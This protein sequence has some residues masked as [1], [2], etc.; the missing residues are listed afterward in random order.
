MLTVRVARVDEV[1]GLDDGETVPAWLGAE[2]RRRW[3]TLG[4]VR[5]R[6]FAAGRRLLRDTLARATGLPA[7]IWE[8]SAQAGAAPLVQ[9]PATVRA[10]LSHRL[11]WMAAA[12]SDGAVGIDVEPARP[13]RSDPAGRAALMLAPAELV[14]WYALAPGLR[15]AALRTA[16]TAKEAWFKASPPHTTAWDFRRVVA[17]A[18]APADANVRVW[19]ASPLHVAVCSVDARELARV[20]CA[21]LGSIAAASTFWHVS[22]G[23]APA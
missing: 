21:G 5:R 7:D 10:S 1:A 23:G 14:A 18:C 4:A 19:E 11:G 8:I 16:W 22:R 17:R 12:V 6:E 15:E 3:T 13:P 20:E 9:G 2:E